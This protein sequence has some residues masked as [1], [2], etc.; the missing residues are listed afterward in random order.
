[1]R[2]PAWLQRPMFVWQPPFRPVTTSDSDQS[3]AALRA[4]APADGSW[5]SAALQR[6]NAT[7]FTGRPGTVVTVNQALTLHAA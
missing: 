1:M 4:N 5:P 3:S 2:S 6:C 7:G